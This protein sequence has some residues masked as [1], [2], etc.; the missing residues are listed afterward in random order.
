MI[1]SHKHKFIFIR[2]PKTASTSVE[3]FCKT[4]DND[5]IISNENEPPYGHYTSSQVKNM[6]T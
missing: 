6:V 5:C 3:Q 1:I 4:I 2:I